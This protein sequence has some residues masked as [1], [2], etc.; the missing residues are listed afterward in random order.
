MWKLDLF[1]PERTSH[2]LRIRVTNEMDYAAALE[3][4][5][6]KYTDRAKPLRVESVQGGLLTELSFA[7][8]LKPGA[9]AH[10]FV[11]ELQRAAGNNRVV[12]VSSGTD[13]QGA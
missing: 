10:E 11:T 5:F 2:L 1:A 13:E 12:L 4:V 7:V 9:S 6:A 8:R 3:P